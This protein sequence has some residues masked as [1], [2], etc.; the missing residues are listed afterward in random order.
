MLNNAIINFRNR[1]LRKSIFTFENEVAI[2]IKAYGVEGSAVVISKAK[3]PNCILGLIL[4]ENYYSIG[5][6]M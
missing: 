5:N 3:N 6:L 1:V 2:G 4:V